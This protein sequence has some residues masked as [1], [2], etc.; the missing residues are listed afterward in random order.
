M[1]SAGRLQAA[2]ELLGS[3]EIDRRPAD[4]V[5]NEFFRARRFIGAGDRREISENVWSVIRARC[6]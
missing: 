3:I 1:T 2:I 4:A 6:R 5:A